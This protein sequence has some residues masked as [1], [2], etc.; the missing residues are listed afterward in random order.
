[1]AKALTALAVSKAKPRATPYKIAAGGGL[2][3]L[4]MPNGAKYWR[5]KY[6][7]GTTAGGKRK[8]KTLAI[9]VFPDVSLAEARDAR[10]SA[11]ALHA[12]GIDPAAARKVAKLAR[13][14]PDED[15]LEPN[16]RAWLALKKD[17]WA[18]SHYDKVVCRLEN[19]VFPVLGK[20][21]M[22][23][24]TVADVLGLLRMIEAS[25]SPPLARGRRKHGG[26]DTAHRVCQHLSKIF[27]LGVANGKCDSNPTVD[28]QGVLKARVS[29]SF[30]TITDPMRVGELLR[31][32]EG[33]RG[34]F[35]TRALLRV[36]PFLF[37]RPSEMRLAEWTE[38][39]LDAASWAVPA[40]RMKRRKAGKENGEAHLV[41]LSR[42]V[43]AIL[44]DLQLMSGG[45]RYVFPSVKNPRKP[46][47]ANTLGKAL[48][49]LGFKGQ[50][51]PHGF[52]HMADTLLHE[53][54]WSDTAI[55]RQ[56]AH[57]DGNKVRRIYNQAQYMAERQRMMQAWADY[58]V[59]LR[60][61]AEIVS[62][63]ARRQG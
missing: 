44:R 42:Q 9:G 59:R 20:R 54:G 28:L 22:R 46:L 36:S 7:Y 55:E 13:N 8:E 27:V 58:L 16:A 2:F 5:W 35:S 45:G 31:A 48:E 15:T 25:G 39:D 18:A 11:R 56:L 1:M 19:H 60:D 37:Q 12:Q 6:R 33:Y 4:V 50:I 40:A 41:P 23:T 61:G 34:Y 43:V 52:R 51:V 57:V 24:I 21:A 17:E 10:D 53:L 3:V 26:I 63:A 62:I 29:H 38:F 14:V 30:P 49:T 32:M 47:S